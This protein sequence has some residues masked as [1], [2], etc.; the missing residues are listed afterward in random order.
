M[1]RTLFVMALA[2][3]AG[4]VGD[5]LLSIGMKSVGRA[6]PLEFPRTVLPFALAMLKTP[7]VILGTLSLAAF[8]FLWTSALSWADLS[9]VLPLTAGNFVLTAI[10][11]RLLLHEQITPLRWLGTFVISLG[12]VLVVLGEHQAK[13]SRQPPEPTRNEVAAQSSAR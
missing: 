2:V 7:M 12:I 13:V 5:L 6:V 3:V 1:I 9:F 11:A 4:T 8:F 10:L